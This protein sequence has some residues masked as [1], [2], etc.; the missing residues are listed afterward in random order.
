MSGSASAAAIARTAFG[1]N[2]CRTS[3]KS[4]SSPFASG[5]SVFSPVGLPSRLG[6]TNTRIRPAAPPAA[7][8][9]ATASVSSLQPSQ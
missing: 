5:T 9:R 8:S 2:G 7:S 6:L 3:F 4:R 1:E